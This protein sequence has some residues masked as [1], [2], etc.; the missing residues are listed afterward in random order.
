M[1]TFVSGAIPAAAMSAIVFGSAGLPAAAADYLP[2]QP[3]AATEE[4]PYPPPAYGYQYAPP[5]VQYAYPP[6]VQY[7]YPPPVVV[8]PPRVV[9]A[10]APYYRRYAYGPVYGAAPV[11][12]APAYGVRPYGAYGH[13]GRHAFRRW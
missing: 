4:Y 7:V 10:P 11:Y 2:P 3:P 9:V 8:A 5:P 12:R 1:R 6:P 13:Y